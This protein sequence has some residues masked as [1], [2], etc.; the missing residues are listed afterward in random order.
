M[1]VAMDFSNG[2]IITR[3]IVYT[4]GQMRGMGIIRIH[5]VVEDMDYT[6]HDLM[7][8]M[9]G[10]VGK[11]TGT[12]WLLSESSLKGKNGRCVCVI[13]FIDEVSRNMFALKNMQVYGDVLKV[14]GF[15]N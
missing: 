14:M 10:R 7:Q 11:E 15:M 3:D 6:S 5:N 4:P 13:A 8:E 9:M 1:N 12:Q 2:H